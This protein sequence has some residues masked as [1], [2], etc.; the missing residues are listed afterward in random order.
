[1]P[2][3]D[4]DLHYMPSMVPDKDEVAS[5]ARAKKNPPA[6]VETGGG[7]GASGILVGFLFLLV[8]AVGG[9]A[10]WQYTELE[11]AKAR[12]L[13]L[14][15]RLSS[16]GE[17]MSQS[18]EEM[19]VKLQ[20]QG[21]KIDELWTQM[22]KLW[23]SAWRR[24]QKEI[25]DLRKAQ[26]S[27]AAKSTSNARAIA[28]LNQETKGIDGLSKKIAKLDELQTF[29][30]SQADSVDRLKSDV[31]GLKTQQR[32]VSKRVKDSEDW[33]QSSMGFRR[34]V[35]R[36]YEELKQSVREIQAEMSAAAAQPVENRPAPIV[37]ASTQQ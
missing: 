4:D 26:E 3:K 27:G 13:N 19:A 28:A 12:V 24:N 21:Q 6:P 1:M 15:E 16:T 8:L 14:E 29:A 22:D 34:Q 37:D 2:R 11:K 7:G 35:N 9:F 20:G 10:G 30:E 36:Q 33:V 23:A 32:D 5:Y 31:A 17:T 25:A 18:T